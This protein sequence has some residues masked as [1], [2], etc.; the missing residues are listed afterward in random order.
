MR[1]LILTQ[2]F[3]PEIG[4]PQIRLAAL[5]RCLKVYGHEVEVVTALPHHLIGKI[6]PAYQHKI[7]VKDS[8]EGITVHRTW[9]YAATGTGFARLIN[10]LS[11]AFTCALGTMRA[12]RPDYVFV[13]SPPLFLGVTGV[14][15]SMFRRV[16]MIFNVADLWPDSVRELGI[17]KPGLLLSLAERVEKWIYKRS[18][19]VNSVTEGIRHVLIERKEVLQSKVLILPNGVDTSLF[20]PRKPDIALAKELKLDDHRIFVYA[21]THGV[22]QGL[23]TLMDAAARLK[24]YGVALL[25]IGDGPAKPMLLRRVTEANLTNVIFVGMQP[26]DEMPRFFSLATASIVPLV[27]G[28]LF[29]SARP[30]KILTSLASGVPVIFCGEGETASFLDASRAG[31]VVPPEDPEALADAIERLAK[32]PMLRDELATNARRLA[33]NFDWNTL[34]RRWLDDLSKAQDSALRQSGSTLPDGT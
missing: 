16:P 12:K 26:V 21:G 7:Y 24:T 9:A 5:A 8:F 6:Y 33:Q 10:Y 18:R 31:L 14:A 30:S 3:P 2:Y 34:V 15:Y 17:L 23:L 11:F 20:A 32:D 1:F 22:A 29:K 19:F 27:K 28:D 25:F 13:E 4:A